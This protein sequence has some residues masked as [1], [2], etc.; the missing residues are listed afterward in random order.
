MIKL[1]MPPNIGTSNAVLIMRPAPTLNIKIAVN[2][3]ITTKLFLIPI[4]PLCFRIE[5]MCVDTALNILVCVHTLS[6]YAH[7]C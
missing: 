1:V 4:S 2:N 7:K 3:D 6:T 5:Y